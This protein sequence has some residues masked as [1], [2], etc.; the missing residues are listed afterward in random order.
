MRVAKPFAS[1]EIRP[2][3]STG[4]IVPS[5]WIVRYEMTNEVFSLRA[6]VISQL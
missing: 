3:N 1:R 5:R 6:C 4:R 2:C